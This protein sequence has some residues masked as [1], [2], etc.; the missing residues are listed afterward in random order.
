[1]DEIDPVLSGSI[2]IE[3]SG[4]LSDQQKLF[5]GQ[6]ATRV[7]ENFGLSDGRDCDSRGKKVGECSVAGK[8]AGECV[9]SASTAGEFASIDG[10]ASLTAIASAVVLADPATSAT[11]APEDKVA[12]KSADKA[13]EKSGEKAG[14]VVAAAPSEAASKSGVEKDSSKGILKA[15]QSGTDM[16]TATLSTKE[17]T[18]VLLPVCGT[19]EASPIVKK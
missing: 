16:K 6:I 19:L 12:E 11:A 7:I 1:M 10:A 17:I 8:T 14:E 9:H 13:D 3:K 18:D 5:C 2:A 4:E 15:V